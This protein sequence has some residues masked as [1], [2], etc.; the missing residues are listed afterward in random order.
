MTGLQHKVVLITGASGGI[1]QSLAAEFSRAG[2]TVVISS[3]NEEKLRTFWR[4]RAI[5]GWYRDRTKFA[6]LF[7]KVGLSGADMGACYLL[8][9]VVGLGKA[10]E[11]LFLGDTIDAEEAYRIGLANRVIEHEKLV[12]EADELA[13]RLKQGP[14]QAIGVTK[15]LLERETNMDLES[16]LTLEAAAQ[17]GCMETADF[18]RRV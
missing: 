6:F 11:L 17:A 12:Q 5:L 13:R 3:R 9:R 1:G 2:T 15:D 14:L 4:W 10:T 18:K 7:V 16:A 8:P